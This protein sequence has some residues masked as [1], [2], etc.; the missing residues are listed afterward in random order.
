MNLLKS[1]AIVFILTFSLLE[2]TYAAVYQI[3]NDYFYQNPAELSQVNDTQL[4]LGNAIVMPRFEFNGK[5]AIGNGIASSKANNSLPYLLTAY[6]F[7]DKLVLG[8]NAT[9][10]GYGHIDWPEDSIVANASTVTNVLYYQ[11]GLQSEYQ[12]NNKL[13]V[14]L[15]FNIEYNKFAELNYM[16]PPLGNQVNK[17]KNGVNYV[18]DVGLYYKINP[19]N[20][21]TSAVYTQ[22][23]TYG[24][25]FSTL[26]PIISNDFSL[27]VLQ[28]LIAYLGL[29]HTIREK[30]FLEEKIY[31]S[32]WTIGK[33]V[34]FI[35]SAKG[36]FSTPANWG[37][38]WSF[39][40]SARYILTEKLGVLGSGTYETN[41]VPIATNQIGYPV[42][43]AGALSIGLDFMMIKE[44]SA[45][46]MYSYGAFIPNAIIANTTGNGTV[47]AN[48]QSFVAQ[49]AY[50]S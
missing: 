7:T 1:S 44:L 9:P 24:H 19:R 41:P 46:I 21:L 50:K 11:F 27:N 28:A 36:S 48:T 45:Q 15:G 6:R 29:Q 4:V 25:G 38:A 16:V 34:D 14:G 10:S 23:S 8:F 26:G 17:I 2:N 31:F 42:S 22:V 33:N 43:S 40:I 49:L 18:G 37:D 47:S 35:N 3:L 32:N 13:S 12:F 5:T 20:Y 39:Q 30:L